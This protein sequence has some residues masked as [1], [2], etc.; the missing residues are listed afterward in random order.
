MIGVVIVSHSARLAEGVCE[1]AAQVAR[2]KVRLAAAGGTGDAANPIGTDAFA[3]LRAIE[4]VYSDDGVLVLMDLGSAVLSAETALE[5]L[6]ERRRAHVRLCG[7]PLVE[8]AVAAVSQAAAGAGIDEIAREA[9][10]A[11]AAKS[12]QLGEASV[13]AAPASEAPAD[14]E[15]ALATVAD[16]LGLHARPAAR[17]IRAARLFQAA[18]TI[19]NLTAGTGPAPAGSIQGVLGLGARRGDRLRLRARGTDARE[20]VAALAALIEEAHGEPA[21]PVPGPQPVAPATTAPGR[22]TGLPAAGGVAI[23]PL[24]HLVP[25]PVEIAPR[26]AGD[27]VAEWQRLLAALRAAQEETRALYGWAKA[28]AGESEA[29]IFEAQALFLEDP[30]LLDT[31]GR[32]VREGR[33]TAE[34]AWD[35]ATRQCAASLAA[36]DDPYLR[37]RA[38]DVTDV[39]ARVLRRLTGC[40][41]ALPVPREPSILAAR[42]LAPSE[43]KQLDPARVVGLCLEAA[44]ASAHSV[45]LARAMGFPVVV[46]LGPGISAVPEGTTVALD[47]ERGTVWVAPGA[48]EVDKL[49]SRRAVWLAARQEARAARHAP[50]AT[51]DGRAIRVYANINSVAG[52]EEALECGAQGV[53]VLRT[54]FLFLNRTAA[55]DEEE[56]FVAYRAIAEILGARPLVIRTLDIGGDKSLPYI[57]TAGESN[58]FLGFRGI[59]L[60]LGRRD[61]LRTQ[62]RA[63]L[64]AGAGYR[65]EVLLPMISSLDEVRQARTALEE[66]A[67]ELA[68]EGAAFATGVPLGVMIEVP[69]AAAIAGQLARE[70]AFF[71]IGTNDL[72][73]YVMAADRTNPRVAGLADPFQPAVLRTVHQ[74]IQAGRRAGI[75]VTLCGEF[76]AD[77][78]ATA[79]LIGLGLEEFSVS[80]PLI[81][82]LKR[83][84]AAV[85][86]PAAEDLAR[87][88]LELESPGAVRRLA[89]S[90][91]ALPE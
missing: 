54:E 16:P 22:L 45:I 82:D 12:A 18:A 36:L 8:G 1:L 5:L 71:S 21:P 85:A 63:I 2:D 35:T 32:Q 20:A 80:A 76:A 10:G 59:R 31:A 88:V 68:R 44:S 41:S 65:V 17:F 50:A 46:G 7:A 51:R 30:L 74:T 49:A 15:E 86:V 23:G 27:P 13:P 61:L 34:A 66:A 4:E 14:A 48:A 25:A 70:A 83:A 79:L 67:V 3:V 75:G 69:A 56:Q 38:A 53:G 89:A 42:D 91:A 57:D 78:L 58:P 29:G 47:G 62:L 72:V 43:V 52:A 60:T 26:A 37:A 55:P 28:H 73:Q 24:L 87:R 77:P 11:L 64:R 90:G 6:D 84:I 19:E 40:G 9:A 33:A 81:P 39:A